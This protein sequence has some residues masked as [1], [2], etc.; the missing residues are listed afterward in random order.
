MGFGV[1]AVLRWFPE[2]RRLERDHAR[3]R[4]QQAEW[5]RFFPPGHFYSPLPSREEV[6]TV[7]AR[8][9]FGPESN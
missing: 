4:E 8:G 9:G 7:F 5:A 3:L 1:R 6:A 2:F